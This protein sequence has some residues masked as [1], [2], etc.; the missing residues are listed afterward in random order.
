M[1]EI[2]NKR[3]LLSIG[4]RVKLAR[5][6]M[7]LT[8]EQ[9]ADRYG[10]PRT[11]LAKL[12]AGHRDFKSTE[13]VAL[14]DQLGVSCDYLLGRERAAAPDDFI[15]EAVNRYG[16]DERALQTLER[17][18]APLGA[19]SEEVDRVINMQR[20]ADEAIMIDG[21]LNALLAS[22]FIDQ[23]S[24]SEINVI[25]KRVKTTLPAQK[26]PDE[27]FSVVVLVKQIEI[28]KQI[29][30]ALNEILTTPT[31]REFPGHTETYGSNILNSIYKYCHCEQGIE[32]SLDDPIL[33]RLEDT[34]TVE[35]Q[36]SR[37]VVN[38]GTNLSELRNKLGVAAGDG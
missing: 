33:G 38:I 31:G 26:L 5:E 10:Y 17:L 8:Q 28:N 32:Y 29:L 20:A 24:K 19:D 27:E 11:T 34:I 37:E 23:N 15:Q 1:S 25:K 18:N 36:C 6:G 22:S 2:E 30:T 13:I 35:D 12:E 4:S 16:L 14:A 21:S 9:F 7:R 3:R